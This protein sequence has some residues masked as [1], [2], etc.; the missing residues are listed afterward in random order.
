[1]ETFN[2]VAMENTDNLGYKCH[3]N[4]QRLRY[5]ELQGELY[6]TISGTNG[7]QRYQEAAAWLK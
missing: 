4:L 5:R 7:I 3:R 2:K 6:S 1:M